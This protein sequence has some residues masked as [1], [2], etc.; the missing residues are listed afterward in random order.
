MFRNIVR[1]M[2]QF[3]FDNFSKT[4]TKTLKRML[5]EGGNQK[6]LRR[7]NFRKNVRDIINFVEKKMKNISKFVSSKTCF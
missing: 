4:K 6:P 5:F 3:V 7:Q 2:F 1:K